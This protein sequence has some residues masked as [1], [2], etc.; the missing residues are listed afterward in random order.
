[1]VGTVYPA[2]RSDGLQERVALRS[3][4]GHNSPRCSTDFRGKIEFWWRCLT[5]IADIDGGTTEDGRP[6]FVMEYIDGEPLDQWPIP[7]GGLWSASVPQTI[8][9][10]SRKS[11]TTASST[12]TSNRQH[13]DRS[14]W[15]PRRDD[16]GVAKDLDPTRNCPSTIAS[17]PPNM[18]RPEQFLGKPTN[19]GAT[20]TP[21]ASF[22]TN[23][24][25]ANAL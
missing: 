11:T 16:F 10:R 1:M 25:L 15:T 14:E 23:F 8:W 4:R 18:P 5:P 3:A 17:P 9:M 20:S 12:V 21:L 19:A 6:F 2:I 13:S 7:T 24:S 22:Y